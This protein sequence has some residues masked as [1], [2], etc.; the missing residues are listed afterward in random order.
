M[1]LAEVLKE[2]NA[3]KLSLIIS[4]GI[5]SN[6]IEKLS[7]TFD[8]VFTTNSFR[9]IKDERITQIEVR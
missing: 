5:F 9:D 2:K 4:H 7:E 8:H 3:G 6:G 1:G